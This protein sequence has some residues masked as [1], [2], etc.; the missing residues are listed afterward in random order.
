MPASNLKQI[1]ELAARTV[2][3][4]VK[5]P[6]IAEVLSLL[7]QRLPQELSYHSLAHTKDVLA[8]AIFFAVYD[9]RS[10]RELELI[11]IAA[12]FHDAGYMEGFAGHE[13]ASAQMVGEA[14]ERHGGY[15]A[16]EISLVETMILDTKLQFTPN[17]VI[18]RARADLSQ[19]LLDA[20]LSNF[21][22]ED[23]FDRLEECHREFRSNRHK[24]LEQTLEFMKSHEW[25]TA[26]GRAL[27]QAR[28]R[29][30]IEELEQLIKAATTAAQSEQSE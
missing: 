16:E 22:R 20:D 2:E 14:M 7:A 24:L 27:R 10:E 5:R 21:G 25:L 30:N 23:F 4:A 29:Q 1:Q 11:A 3:E 26:A 28:K 13:A 9:R 18:Q 19:Y 15:T 12:A 6:I 8:E 17:A